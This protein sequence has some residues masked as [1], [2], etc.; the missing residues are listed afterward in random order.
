MHAEY[1]FL[2]IRSMKWRD[3]CDPEKKACINRMDENFRIN[4][5]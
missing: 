5:V 2:Y 3:P 4:I 1:I